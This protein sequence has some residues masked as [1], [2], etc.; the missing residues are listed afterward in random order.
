MWRNLINIL[1]LVPSESIDAVS[2]RPIIAKHNQFGF[3][4][5]SAVVIARALT[6]I[7]FLAVQCTVSGIIIYFMVRPKG[8]ILGVKAWDLMSP[9]WLM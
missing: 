6:D 2:G 5:P 8:P 3:H 7:P 4:R 1:C 9:R